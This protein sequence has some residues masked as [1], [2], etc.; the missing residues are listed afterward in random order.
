MSKRTVQSS[1]KRAGNHQD[2]RR[3]EQHQSSLA[4]FFSSSS[5]NSKKSRTSLD[6]QSD[7]DGPKKANGF[8][9]FCDLD[10]VLVNF[11]AGVRKVFRGRGPDELPNPGV[12]WGGINKVNEFYAHLPWMEDGKDLWAAIKHTRPTILTG[13]P[14]L[15]IAREHKAIWCRRELGAEANHIDKAGP[16]SSHEVVSGVYRKGM[17]NVI[18][19]WSK[20][21][22]VESGPNAILIDDRISLRE[23]WEQKG[24]IFIHHTDTIS[25]LAQLKSKGILPDRDEINAVT[26]S[27]AKE[28]LREKTTKPAA[29]SFV[30][31]TEKGYDSP[32]DTP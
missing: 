8:K 1:L 10:G 23:A 31:L 21:K 7:D 27:S 25:T 3:K 13:V 14:R 12:L 20:N 4:G 24:G 17:V 30:D 18:T 26:D 16:K 22:H 6:A 28:D 29:S 32:P 11:D 9:I 19:C 5:H 2:K 15:K